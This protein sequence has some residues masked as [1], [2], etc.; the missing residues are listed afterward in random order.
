MLKEMLLKKQAVFCQ[1]GLTTI[2]NE[3]EGNNRCTELYSKAYCQ[4]QIQCEPCPH[5]GVC[6]DGKVECNSYYIRIANTCVHDDTESL[7]IYN[8]LAEFE[9]EKTV[10]ELF[11]ESFHKLTG[12]GKIQLKRM[13]QDREHFGLDFEADID[14]NESYTTWKLRK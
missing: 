13:I 6:E 8:A 12:E 4:N 1:T 10:G 11:P 7:K 9:G 5:H 14:E 3:T 2:Y